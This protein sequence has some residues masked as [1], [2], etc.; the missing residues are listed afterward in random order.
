RRAGQAD[1]AADSTGHGDGAAGLDVLHGDLL[2]VQVDHG[3]QGPGAVVEVGRHPV[4]HPADVQLEVL[5]E[6]EAV[7]ACEHD[8]AAEDRLVRRQVAG[9]D[10]DLDADGDRVVG[11]LRVGHAR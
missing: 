11:R 3:G 7:G 5:D 1:G 6:P 4:V 9:H 8:H 2:A 10:L